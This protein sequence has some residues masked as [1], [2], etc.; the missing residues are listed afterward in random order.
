MGDLPALHL[1][2]RDLGVFPFAEPSQWET[3]EGETTEGDPALPNVQWSAVAPKATIYDFFDELIPIAD[4]LADKINYQLGIGAN[5]DQLKFEAVNFQ[6]DKDEKGGDWLHTALKMANVAPALERIESNNLQRW[7]TP[8]FS[9]PVF[10]TIFGREDGTV[11]I[12]AKIKTMQDEVTDSY[13]LD[14]LNSLVFP[15][16]LVTSSKTATGNGRTLTIL[17]YGPLF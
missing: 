8:S 12:S 3:R 5:G 9:G 11:I 6:Y 7:F 4:K 16:P 10:E 15:L 1:A 14:I 2:T 13:A 17:G